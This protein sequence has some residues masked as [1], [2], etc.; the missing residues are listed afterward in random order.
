VLQDLKM[1]SFKG[2]PV[3]LAKDYRVI[4]KQ[5]FPLLK[6]LDGICAFTEAEEALK[7]KNKKKFDA[8]GHEILDTSDL[9]QID[10]KVTF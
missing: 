4:L 9:I 6:M 7:K 5:R 3:C 8:Y 1:V 2:S 10:P